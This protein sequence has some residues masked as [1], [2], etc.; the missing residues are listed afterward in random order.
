[1]V[2]A[3]GYARVSTSEQA[4]NGGSID[5]QLSRIAGYCNLYEMMLIETVVDAGLSAKDTNRPGFLKAL[6][7]IEDGQ[8][9][10]LVVVKLDRLTRSVRD[11]AT[12]L[13]KFNP[14]QGG[15]S[16]VSV[17]EHL[18]TRTASGRLCLNLLVSVSQWERE[19]IGE[20]TKAVLQHK[21][22]TGKVYGKVPY[23]WRREGDNLVKDDAQQA[24]IIE[25]RAR[26]T[27]GETL[28]SVLRDF[29][30]RKVPAACGP[31]WYYR[32]LE[33]VVKRNENEEP[34]STI[35]GSL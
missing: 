22:H 30:K 31:T 2:K 7:M 21:K 26:V 19:V 3:I 14:D 23:G 25:A 27:G 1:M 29:T 32:A 15:P 18:D 35:G 20:R 24:I 17:T 12:L 13:E 8:A 6:R 5:A 11:L 9:D 4:E 34:S 28:A 16:L 10:C 33:R